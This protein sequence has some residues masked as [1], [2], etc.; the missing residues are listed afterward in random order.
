MKG[1]SFCLI[2][3]AITIFVHN[4]KYC[5]LDELVRHFEWIKRCKT[6]L[7]WDLV[8]Q[9]LRVPLVFDN[10]QMSSKNVDYISFWLPSGKDYTFQILLDWKGINC[11]FKTKFQLY[12]VIIVFFWDYSRS[13]ALIPSGIRNRPSHTFSTTGIQHTRYQV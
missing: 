6:I 2:K 4:S 5:F 3:S 9:S 8:D 1:F 13:F 10:N 7:E 11:E 12:R